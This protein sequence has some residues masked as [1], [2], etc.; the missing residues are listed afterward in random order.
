MI[1]LTAA[2]VF[3]ILDMFSPAISR[4]ARAGAGIGIG[5]A[6]IGGLPTAAAAV[7]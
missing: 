3:A 5:L 1:A 7:L 4:G 6:T 2:A